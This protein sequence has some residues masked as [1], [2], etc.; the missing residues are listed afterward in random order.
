[1]FFFFKRFA[2]KLLKCFELPKCY[3][4]VVAHDEKIFK[5]IYFKNY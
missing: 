3:N 5:D 2:L 4:Y 1:M